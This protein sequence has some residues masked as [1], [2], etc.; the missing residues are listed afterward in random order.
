MTPLLEYQA[1]L[2]KA[3]IASRQSNMDQQQKKLFDMN[4]DVINKHLGTMKQTQ[5]TNVQKNSM[6]QIDNAFKILNNKL[7]QVNA[8]H[9]GLSEAVQTS[10]ALHGIC[11]ILESRQN[12]NAAAFNQLCDV[13]EHIKN[14]QCTLD[15]NHQ[16]TVSSL[17]GL[18]DTSKNHEHKLDQME[19]N[20]KLQSMMN[21]KIKKF[22]EQSCNLHSEH[23]RFS[24]GSTGTALASE[25]ISDIVEKHAVLEKDLHHL[26]EHTSS[27]LEN[28]AD[29]HQSFEKSVSKSMHGIIDLCSTSNEAKTRKILKTMHSSAKAQ[30]VE[31]D[32]CLKHRYMKH[33]SE[34]KDVSCKE[35]DALVKATEIYEKLQS[36]QNTVVEKNDQQIKNNLI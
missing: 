2:D 35:S 9:T 4:C 32:D 15:S 11:D 8:L 31:V 22:N 1:M 19:T 29:L 3:M 18:H 14:K 6:R 28:L 36:I 13:I 27:S 30:M 34:L 17:K 23:T 24:A 12:E 26:A 25:S 16:A 7:K 33:L 10:E 5:N 20:A 21:E